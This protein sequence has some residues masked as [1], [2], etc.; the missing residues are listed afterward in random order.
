MF[1]FSSLAVY[2]RRFRVTPKSK[3]LPHQQFL[4]K[5]SISGSQYFTVRSVLLSKS[6]VFVSTA[7]VAITPIFSSHALYLIFPPSV[8]VYGSRWPVEFDTKLA[9]DV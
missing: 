5:N 2:A 7:S 6:L 8:C 3:L 4:S 1:I 9:N